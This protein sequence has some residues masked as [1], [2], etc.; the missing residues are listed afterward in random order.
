MKSLKTVIYLI[1]ILFSFGFSQSVL[2]Q[3][4]ISLNCH[5]KACTSNQ[6]GR[7]AVSDRH[8]H[9]ILVKCHKPYQYLKKYH[10]RKHR[11]SHV[12]CLTS[13]SPYSASLSCTS[14]SAD[15]EHIY[16]SVYCDNDPCKASI[17][18]LC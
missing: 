5:A 11:H 4:H 6:F 1:I 8:P 16:I 15:T 10:V 3:Y 13:H 7:V 12:T 17:K 18:A 9:S 2:A 14:S